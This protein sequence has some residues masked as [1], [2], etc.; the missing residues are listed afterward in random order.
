MHHASHSI[1]QAKPFTAP[2]IS[3]G[4]DDQN[5]EA[6]RPFPAGYRNPE[7][8]NTS[9]TVAGDRKGETPHH[10]F[11]ARHR[12]PEVLDIAPPPTT[13]P[14]TGE[15]GEPKNGEVL[16]QG[17]GEMQPHRPFSTGLRNAGDIVVARGRDIRAH[18][19]GLS[20]G[21]RNTADSDQPHRAFPPDKRNPDVRGDGAHRP[22]A[23]MHRNPEVLGEKD[24][25]SDG[26][27]GGSGAERGE[28]HRAFDASYRNREAG[29]QDKGDVKPQGRESLQERS[30]PKAVG[31]VTAASTLAAEEVN[32]PKAQASEEVQP[33]R[34]FATPYRNPVDGEV[35]SPLPIGDVRKPD[36]APSLSG[37]RDEVAS[38]SLQGIASTIPLLPVKE[39]SSS[40]ATPHLPFQ[41]EHR[42]A[43]LRNPV[44]Q[45]PLPINGTASKVPEPAE[46]KATLS[47]T[48]AAQAPFTSDFPTNNPNTN[49]IS[50]ALS[51]KSFATAEGESSSTGAVRIDLS[52]AGEAENGKA[53]VSREMRIAGASGD[54]TELPKSSASA[55]SRRSGEVREDGR[56][57]GL[58]RGLKNSLSR[59]RK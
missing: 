42:N 25:G 34:A 52:D 31:H 23:V 47:T 26:G 40:T 24:V 17:V 57:R 49:P 36:I 21:K 8:V 44:E 41:P 28:V 18:Q 39:V 33:H 32:E 9:T 6:H 30:S 16:L 20:A 50:P 54:S 22:F 19:R 29:V 10:P 27:A 38:K 58:L 14:T 51:E 12:N 53:L 2:Q 11:P 56:E 43:D 1:Y 13:A 35:S 4:A 3:V 37:S 5:R 59:R 46:S 15:E 48:Q 55:A 45:P 7:D